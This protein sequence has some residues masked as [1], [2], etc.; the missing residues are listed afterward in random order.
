MRI[1]LL[2]L[3]PLLVLLLCWSRMAQ[4][5]PPPASCSGA[6]WPLWH[7]FAER[8]LLAD[9]RIIDLQSPLRHSTS[10]GQA[11][12]MF[13]AL[14]ANDRAAFDRMLRWTEEKLAGGKLGAHLP[15][16]QWN[17]ASGILD[18]NSAS[19]ADLWLAYDLIEAGRLWRD[20]ALTRRGTALLSAIRAHEVIT[21]AGLGTVLLPGANGFVS[22]TGQLR[23]NPSYSPLPVLRRLATVDMAGPWLALANSST[24]L[25]VESASRGMVADWV[26][27]QPGTGFITDV[28]TGGIG[29]YDA[30]RVYLWLG[31]S[32]PSDPLAR[33]QTAVLGG[34]ALWLAGHADLPEKID[35]ASGVASGT[36]PTGFRAAILP[37]LKARGEHAQYSVLLA[38]LRTQLAAFGKGRAT[39]STYYDLVLSLFG[40][41]WSDD[42]FHFSPEGE[43]QTRWEKPCPSATQP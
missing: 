36:A 31:M 23:L 1:A 40:V 42:Y 17:S 37:Y 3:L 38:R 9:G 7:A 28:S 32:T 30:I 13:F 11:Y 14:V 12:G 2:R 34:P 4:A 24:R 33:R 43:L 25:I 20:P 10:E 16:W 27:W 18:T 5:V 35:I 26:G 22:E 41:G 29:S 6:S 8:H 15:A 39:E 21:M 19:D